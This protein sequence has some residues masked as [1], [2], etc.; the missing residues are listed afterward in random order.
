MEQFVIVT[1]GTFEKIAAARVKRGGVLRVFLVQKVAVGVGFVCGIA[2]NGGNAQ[3]F[4]R[5]GGHL[6]LE[7]VVIEPCHRHRRDRKHGI[8]ARKPL[9]LLDLLHSPA[10]GRRHLGNVGQRVVNVGLVAAVGLLIEMVKDIL[11]H[12]FNPLGRHICPLAVDVVNVFIHHLLVNVHCFD[13]IHA[14]R[15]DIVI[16]D[17]VH[18]GVGVQLVAKSLLGREKL[19]GVRLLRVDRENRR[20]GKAE[21]MVLAEI[22]HNRRVHIA[23]LGTMAFVKD[24]DNVLLIDR[25]TGIFL[26]KGCQLLNG[27]NDD[28]AVLVLKL[29]FQNRRAGV[30]V[31]RTLFK[32]VV[33]FHGL[34]VEVFAI[35]DKQNLV[36]IGQCRGKPRGFEGG[37]RFAA[38]RGVPDVTASRDAAVFLI[39]VC[40][41]DAVENS[42]GRR[43]LIRAH[44]EKQILGGENAIARQNIENRMAG[45]K[46][47]G[48]VDEVGNDAIVRVR[49]IGGKFKAVACF[50]LFAGGGARIPDSI[51]A[52]AVGIVF[53]V[54]AVGDDKNLHILKQP[55]TGIKGIALIAVDL[56]ER[57]ADGN[58]TALQFNVN[59]RKAVDEHGHVIAVVVLRAVVFGD[60]VLIGDLQTVVVNVLFVNQR[61]IF[62]TSVIAP[63]N[64]HIVLLH[65]AGLF[66][67]AVVGIGDALGKE[68]LPFAVG[69]AVVVQRFKLRAQ[70][71]D[72]LRLAVNRLVLIALLCQKADKLRF[73]CGFALISVGTNRVGFVFGDHRVFCGRGNDVEV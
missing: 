66:R 40:N 34:I 39:I 44:D 72:Q 12:K 15:Q 7:F 6:S 62:R 33:F 9:L 57:L 4:G 8:E 28:M 54:R 25:V 55:R 61:D 67:N 31:C 5:V 56:I 19:R 48:K 30:G 49:P 23:E 73:E 43:N 65:F 11:G 20:S 29:L 35:H 50:A 36:D 64:L 3:L 69:K 58:A 42:L 37:Q 24:D 13:V 68:P 21:Q 60:Y 41:F 22:L 17:R 26:D 1:D 27:R 63:Q 38:P 32:T 59:K 45:E 14:E 70:V 16:V 52:R 51:K 53:R 2:E 71:G 47:L 10:S 18:N 46:G